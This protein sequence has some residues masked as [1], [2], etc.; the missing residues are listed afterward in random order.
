MTF[1]DIFQKFLQHF[2]KISSITE[3][4][5]MTFLVIDLFRPSSVAFLQWGGGKN[6]RPTSIGGK[7]LKFRKIYTTLIIISS[8]KGGQTPLPTSMGCHGRI[9][10]LKRRG[11]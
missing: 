7:N 9:L 1:L 4:F 2:Q 5:L 3:N 6:P 10:D 11:R 8:S